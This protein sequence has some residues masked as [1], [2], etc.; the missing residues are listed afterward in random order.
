MNVKY[1]FNKILYPLIIPLYSRY[2]HYAY[3]YD[4]RIAQCIRMRP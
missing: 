2:N 3:A 1:N 4:I